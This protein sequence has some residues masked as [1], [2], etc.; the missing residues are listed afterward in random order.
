[1]GCD[2]GAVAGPYGTTTPARTG[3]RGRPFADA[4]SIVEDIIYRYRCGIAWRDV[5]QVFVP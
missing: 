3:R 2:R 5:P 4:R 1:M